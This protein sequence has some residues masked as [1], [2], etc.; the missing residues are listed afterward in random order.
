MFRY[1]AVSAKIAG[2][3]VRAFSA[4]RRNSLG[5]E[6]GNSFQGNRESARRN[7]QFRIQKWERGFS[8]AI[9]AAGPA[10]SSVSGSLAFGRGR[11]NCSTALM[12]G[13]SGSHGENPMNGRLAPITWTAS[14][15]SRASFAE[16]SRQVGW[17]RNFGAGTDG[18]TEIAQSRKLGPP[19]RK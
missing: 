15:R 16:P 10:L 19:G 13:D 14:S 1:L 2:R 4:L 3:N 6:T 8:R 7:R 12:I 9:A 5:N 18:S 11:A 17:P